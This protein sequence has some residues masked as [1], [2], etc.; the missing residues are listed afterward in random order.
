MAELLNI[1]LYENVPVTQRHIELMKT[2]LE[3]YREKASERPEYNSYVDEITKEINIMRQKF[4]SA[5]RKQQKAVAMMVQKQQEVID[6][7]K[8][9]QQM[10]ELLLKTIIGHA[11]S[12]TG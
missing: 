7:A 11:V 8:Q 2:Q 9:E 3:A 5:E 1:N 12:A 10:K 6:K 4:D